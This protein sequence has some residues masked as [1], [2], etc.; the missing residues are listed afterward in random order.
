MEMNLN[1]SQVS[2]ELSQF[3][4]VPS[5]TY[6][7]MITNVEW[8]E[9]SSKTGS[10]LDIVFKVDSGDHAGKQFKTNITI[11]NQSE[12][13][14]EIGH[15]TLKQILTQINHPN[16]DMLKNTSELINGQTFRANVELEAFTT[17]EGNIGYSS[18][19]KQVVSK[20]AKLI[21][22]V[23][24]SQSTRPAATPSAPS[25]PAAPAAPSAPAAPA[26]PAA[27][28]APAGKAPWMK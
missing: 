2:G 4:R 21:D 27:P 20:E 16:P 17:K 7:L 28:S 23:E 10:Y 18:S 19:L 11:A 9:N 12:K 8:K 22:G 3:Q 5:G 24:E 6:D 26:A 1:L 13:A 25:A 15:R 14:V